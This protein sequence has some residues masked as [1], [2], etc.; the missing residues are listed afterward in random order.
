MRRHH[1][2]LLAEDPNPTKNTSE[3]LE[4]KKPLVNTPVSRNLVSLLGKK[5]AS[6]TERAK[7]ITDKIARFIV[8][9]LR[10]FSMVDSPEFRDMIACLDNRYQVPSRKTFSEIVIP[11]MYS[12][13]KV[14][15]QS[16]LREAEQVALTT[17]GWSSRATESYITIT[18]THI[19]KDWNI[20]N[21]V[22]QTRMMPES[23]TGEN[24]AEV[25]RNAVREWNLPIFYGFP[26]VVSDNAANMMKAGELLGNIHVN[27][28]AH[29]LNLACQ[30]CLAVKRLE[31]ILAKIRKIVA[32]FHRSNIAAALLKN[33]AESLS[34]PQHKLIMDVRTRW[35]SAYDMIS[36]FLEMQVA[37][38]AT[39]KSKE[40]GKE[41][42]SELKS[43]HDDDFSVA[44][45]VI[46]LLKPFKDITTL[47]CS[48]KSPTLSII[49]PLHNKLLDKL[50]E[51]IDD[52]PT[53]R[54]MKNIMFKDLKERYAR[55]E[56][57]LRIVSALDPRFKMLPF[58][59]ENE[60]SAVFSDIVL[61]VCRVQNIIKVKREK[62]N[63]DAELDDVE[64][65]NEPP[66]PSLSS[67]SDSP[68]VSPVKKRVK[69]E[70]SSSTSCGDCMESVLH[71]F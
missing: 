41:R 37:I 6:N 22:L 55:I 63:K 15:V 31:N 29:T 71:S 1:P 62:E 70:D 48:E 28:Y 30:K 12:D 56:H 4:V 13:V 65:L 42:E 35:N 23:H 21:F 38:F 43:F 53:V 16:S 69:A 40:L 2:N 66:L 26:P 50:C 11:K 45:E 25:L 36:R 51:Q 64:V 46:Q 44:E 61:E 32:F 20:C 14:K 34:L 47:L 59:S 8:K 33:T 17:D 27:C 60:R 24:V 54:S 7:K 52:T 19:D 57:T 10:P 5:Y 67:L 9:D 3:K 49:L 58:L 18:S 68:A 39:L